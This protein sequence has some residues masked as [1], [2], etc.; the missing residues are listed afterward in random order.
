MPSSIKPI[1]FEYN[2]DI[3]NAKG[4]FNGT[5][6]KIKRNNSTHE[7][8]VFE[9]KTAPNE[10]EKK[11]ENA[12]RIFANQKDNKTLG[13]VQAEIDADFDKATDEG[14]FISVSINGAV[15]DFYVFESF[16]V[17]YKTGS[18]TKDLNKDAQL[19][20]IINPYDFGNN[21]LQNFLVDQ[22]LAI[23]AKASIDPGAMLVVYQGKPSS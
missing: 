15:A 14:V 21:Q 22:Y 12:P 2:F 3:A 11:Y 17:G 1:I 8:R 10:L 18:Y 19:E 4:H 13:K 7:L 5:V 16:Q 9:G 23:K 20:M 6:D